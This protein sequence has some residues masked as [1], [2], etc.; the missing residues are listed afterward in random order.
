M[1]IIEVIDKIKAFH[2]PFENPKTKDTVKAGDEMQECTGIA[3][4]CQA[5]AEVIQKAHALG[6]NLII[7]HESIFFGDEFTAEELG[8]DPFFIA[9]HKLL[10]DTGIVVWR[11]HDH[12]H[13]MG[14]PFS[15]VRY[16]PD[17]IF[18]GIMSELGWQDYVIGDKLKP[19][20]YKLPQTT[21]SE[22]ARFL[23]DKYNLNG[24]RVVGDLNAPVSTVFICEHIFGGKHDL[25]K[26]LEAHKAD[27][28]IPLEICDWTVSAYIRDAVTLGSPKAI[29]EMGHFNAEE[30]G[31]KYMTKWLPEVLGNEL[32]ITYI[33]SGD[34]FQYLLR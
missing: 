11:D 30:L 13:G 17:Y 25:N 23:L 34:S 2:Q 5:T 32:A 14:K 20:W 10:K 33:Q 29:I 22:L 27:V 19:L 8:E 4:T 16:N 1:K 3:V 15:E 24:L 12:I 28:L 21:V 31:M 9:K 7:T 26:L 18:Y 6:I